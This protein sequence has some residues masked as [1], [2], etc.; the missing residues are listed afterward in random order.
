M[1]K[2]ETI[3]LKIPNLGEAEST[4][5]IEVN[6]KHGSEINENDPLIVL[7]SEKAAMEIP[8]DFK[9]KVIEV[10]VKEGDSVT[11]G[12]V[13][14]KIES[15]K[16]DQSSNNSD[17][18]KSREIKENVIQATHEPNTDSVDF[19]G[20]N[21]GPAV[22]KYARELAINLAAISGTGRNGRV[23][24]D[25]L[26]NYIHA[27]T[28]QEV[29]YPNEEDFKKFG[30]YKV[31]K[32]TKIRALGAKN[33]SASWTS[34]P[35]VTH[36]EEAEMT[37]IN[38][39]RSKQKASPLAFFVKIIASAISQHKIFNSSLLQNDQI[40]IK[41]YVNIGIAVDTPHGLVVPVVKDVLNKNIQEISEEISVLAEKA[42]NKKLL[43]KDLEGSTFTISS[44]GKIGGTGFTPIINPPEVGII[45]LSR[46]KNILRMVKGKPAEVEVI[47]FSLSYDHR[48][49]NGADAGRF[50]DKI[51]D[52]IENYT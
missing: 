44:L 32:L 38:L 2:I 25:D 16:V 46:S 15:I 28:T 23:T 33:M 42:R 48:V 10:L 35:H 13:Y 51:R 7:E 12:Q 19:S 45:A 52:M 3:E 6:I 1:E 9:G 30:N 11:E 4:E 8:S 36:F 21:A 29:S 31:E 26:K 40:L 14:A 34:I 24:K 47:P 20:V 41:D 22:R 39:I 17:E 50:M 18:E 5:I 37:A 27:K 49:I 43:T